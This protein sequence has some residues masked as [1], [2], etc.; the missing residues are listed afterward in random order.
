MAQKCKSRSAAML[1]KCR[2]IFRQ[3]K[4]AML[5][6]LFVLAAMAGAQEYEMSRWTIDGGG[7]M[8]S[9]GGE[10]E[11]SGTIGQADAGSMTG[12]D[13]AL[14]GGFWFELPPSDCNS[15]G[16]VDLLDYD[17]FEACLTG[18]DA[19]LAEGCECFDVN[20]NDTVDLLDFAVAQT[21]FRGS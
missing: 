9:L 6:P 14:T 1:A 18:P 15:T 19:G 10:F 13:F 4:L 8:S 21:V 20:R 2:W 11:L 16:G 5:A 12:G 3:C 7:A 17:D